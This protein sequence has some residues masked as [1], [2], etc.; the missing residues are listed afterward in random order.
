MVETMTAALPIPRTR[1]TA[2]GTVTAKAREVTLKA[3]VSG[4]VQAVSE[5]FLPGSPGYKGRSWCAWIR[6]ITR[7]VSRKPDP[8]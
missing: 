4:V 7:S 2:M 6:P 1:V 8:P 5:H 3:Q